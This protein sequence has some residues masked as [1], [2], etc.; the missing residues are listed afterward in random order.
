M[1]KD[2]AS[3]FQEIKKELTGYFNAKL[4]LYRLELFEKT[5]ITVSAL[6]F[7][8]AVLLVVFFSVFFIFLAI[9]FWLGELLDSIAAG[10]GLVALMYLI[11]LVIL[12]VN[13]QKIWDKIVDL[14][15]GKLIKEEDNDG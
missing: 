8:L 9:G 11:L 14:F 12:L 13:K 3:L 5:S 2:F 15:L 6:F 7:G 4:K 10:M 1:E